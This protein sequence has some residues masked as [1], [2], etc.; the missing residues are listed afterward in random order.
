MLRVNISASYWPVRIFHL[1]PTMFLQGLPVTGVRIVENCRQWACI[2]YKA[3]LLASKYAVAEKSP[4]SRT[5]ALE[6]SMMARPISLHVSLVP[7][8]WPLGGHM[9]EVAPEG[10]A[11]SGGGCIATWKLRATTG[12]LPE[13][14]QNHSRPQAWR[15]KPPADCCSATQTGK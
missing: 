10:Y 1:N 3:V 15:R 7:L 11:S 8:H 4:W 6:S 12:E 9:V 2:E 5:A 13:L 14:I